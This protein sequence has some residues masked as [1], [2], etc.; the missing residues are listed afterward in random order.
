[1][2]SLYKRDFKTLDGNPDFWENILIDL[3]IKFDNPL[4]I[5]SVTIEVESILEVE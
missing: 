5:D 4:D 1:M 3:H 2:S